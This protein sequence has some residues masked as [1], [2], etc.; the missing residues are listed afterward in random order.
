MDTHK[1]KFKFKIKYI[2]FRNDKYVIPYE[3]QVMVEWIS[4][5][6]WH[7]LKKTIYLLSKKIAFQKFDSRR[8]NQ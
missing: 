8:V 6:H 2:Y 3:E 7:Y 1:L 4:Y 5:T